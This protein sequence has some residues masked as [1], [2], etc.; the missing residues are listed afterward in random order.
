M[1]F[2]VDFFSVAD[3]KQSDTAEMLISTLIYG[4]EE[5]E[6]DAVKRNSKRHKEEQIRTRKTAH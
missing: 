6:T 2:A 3:G 1:L 4:R 5:R